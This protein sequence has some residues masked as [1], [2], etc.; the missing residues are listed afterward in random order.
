M[1]HFYKK[2]CNESF[3]HD[4]KT[5]TSYISKTSDLD[6]CKNT[7]TYINNKPTLYIHKPF[8]LLR[9]CDIMAVDNLHKK[10]MTRLL[11]YKKRGF[12]IMTT[13]KKDTYYKYTIKNEPLMVYKNDANGNFEK[14]TFLD[15]VYDRVIMQNVL[16]GENQNILIYESPDKSDKIKHHALYGMYMN[17]LFTCCLNNTISRIMYECNRD[18]YPEEIIFTHNHYRHSCF[19]LTKNHPMS[20]LVVDY[21]VMNKEMREHYDKIFDTT[22]NN[23]DELLEINYYDLK[24]D[25]RINYRDVWHNTAK[26]SDYI[27]IDPIKHKIITDRNNKKYVLDITTD[28][29]TEEDDYPL[30]NLKYLNREYIYE[31]MVQDD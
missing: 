14:L 22:I 13:L 10:N 2:D 1:S 17:D 19:E 30:E 26:E 9:K 28:T 18:C 21:D 15:K 23:D 31:L 6:I 20:F 8:K 7:F 3:I 16:D 12:D 24:D 4:H 27:P 11:K 25:K 29:F 5:L